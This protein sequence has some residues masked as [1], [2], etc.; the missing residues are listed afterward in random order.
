MIWVMWILA[1]VIAL[2]LGRVRQ[3]LQRRKNH[4]LQS[5]TVTLQLESRLPFQQYTSVLRTLLLQGREHVQQ[6]VVVSSYLICL[7]NFT[8]LVLRLLLV[9]L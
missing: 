8:E 6:V 5:E 1:H 2:L 3:H 7:C 9:I 4:S